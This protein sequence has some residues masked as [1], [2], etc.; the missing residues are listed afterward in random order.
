[1]TMNA[2]SPYTS[3]LLQRKLDSSIINLLNKF[4]VITTDYHEDNIESV[5]SLVEKALQEGNGVIILQEYLR[6]YVTVFN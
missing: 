5:K 2:I 4:E 1:M 3:S 6:Y